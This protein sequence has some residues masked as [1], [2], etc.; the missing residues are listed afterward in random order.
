MFYIVSFI[1]VL[2]FF[3]L[4]V[5]YIYIHILLYQY[6]L[7][8]NGMDNKKYFYTFIFLY[9]YIL[10]F[11]YSYILLYVYKIYELKKIY[12]ITLF[13]RIHELCDPSNPNHLT[14]ALSPFLRNTFSTR[15]TSGRIARCNSCS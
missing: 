2:L 9:S 10:I 13:L 7:K 11:L 15:Y 5:S 14:Y 6:T 3:S 8:K 1:Y 12:Q 4:H